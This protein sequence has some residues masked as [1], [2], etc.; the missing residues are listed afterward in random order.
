MVERGVIGVQGNLVM[1]AV[2]R[3]RDGGAIVHFAPEVEDVSV[4]AG[5]LAAG[6]VE[7]SDTALGVDHTWMV[8]CHDPNGI[9][10][11]LHQYTRRSLQ[12]T[13]GMCRI[14]YTA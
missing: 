14:D 12:K 4:A 5:V 7:V 8:T 13:G 3:Q 9:F 10:I 2:V 1:S 11:E 6:G